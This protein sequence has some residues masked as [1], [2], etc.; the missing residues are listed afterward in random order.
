MNIL[1]KECNIEN[2]WYEI[3][4]DGLR[5]GL[6]TSWADLMSYQKANEVLKNVNA[7]SKF[8]K[9]G[10]YQS[11]LLAS[12]T[13]VE[14]YIRKTS[15]VGGVLLVHTPKMNSD[16]PNAKDV[17]YADYYTSLL[18]VALDGTTYESMMVDT[19]KDVATRPSD[20][21]VV[22]EITELG[23]PTILVTYNNTASDG[24]NTGSTRQYT[25]F[26]EGK[27]YGIQVFVQTLLEEFNAGL[28]DV[29]DKIIAGLEVT[30]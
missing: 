28:K 21:Y 13:A 3:W 4:T 7:F 12:Y 25:M 10:K 2:D 6:F 26:P 8:F 1:S 27:S 11:G 29:A 9:L 5:R 18:P 20:G 15:P 24:T 14:S 19:L 22:T 30:E 17:I 23:Y 16:T